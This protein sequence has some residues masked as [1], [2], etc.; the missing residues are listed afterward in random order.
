MNYLNYFISTL[1][2]FRG[3]DFG[4][5]VADGASRFTA[6]PRPLRAPQA[7]RDVSALRTHTTLHRPLMG[8]GAPH[9]LSL[10]PRRLGDAYPS[11][12]AMHIPSQD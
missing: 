2:Y 3:G 1:T 6:P 5:I 11:L 8:R 12:T 10:Q 4:S 7:L 9:G